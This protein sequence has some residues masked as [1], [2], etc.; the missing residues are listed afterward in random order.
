MFNFKGLFVGVCL[1]SFQ[2]YNFATTKSIKEFRYEGSRVERIFGDNFS[3]ED[4]RE[5]VNQAWVQAFGEEFPC[6][7]LYPKDVILKTIEDNLDRIEPWLFFCLDEPQQNVVRREYPEYM[8]CPAFSMIRNYCADL[9]FEELLGTV[10]RALCYINGVV[11]EPLFLP[12]NITLETLVLFINDN[13][14]VFRPFLW[15]NCW[16]EGNVMNLPFQGAP[17]EAYFR[18]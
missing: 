11:S 9:T 3:V 18:D 6:S 2:G 13:L 15:K 5:L 1:L 7:A 14:K 4:V 8:Y 12:K 10:E 17:Q 16:A